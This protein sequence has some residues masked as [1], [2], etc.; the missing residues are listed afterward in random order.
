MKVLACECEKL[1]THYGRFMM[2]ER[3]IR[4]DP[5]DDI[6]TDPV[7]HIVVSQGRVILGVYGKALLPEAEKKVKEVEAATG[8]P[9]FLALVVGDRPEVGTQLSEGTELPTPP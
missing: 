1:I 2:C 7:W 5:D 4:I 6:Y 9:A 3:C 8:F